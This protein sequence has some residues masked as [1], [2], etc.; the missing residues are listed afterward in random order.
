MILGIM[1][2]VIL[3]A[4]YCIVYTVYCH[5]WEDKNKAR[6]ETDVSRGV[7]FISLHPFSCAAGDGGVGGYGKAAGVAESRQ[8][9]SQLKYN[10]THFTPRG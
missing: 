5:V 6:L 4:V 9:M 1:Y 2:S 3:Y 7:L 10:C 8:H